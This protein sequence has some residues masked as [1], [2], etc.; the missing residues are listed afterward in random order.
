MILFFSKKTGQCIGS[1]FGRMHTDVH[2]QATILPGDHTEEEVERVVNEWVVTG[3]DAEGKPIIE[4]EW[5]DKTFWEEI[6]EGHKRIEHLHL[7]TV[8]GVKGISYDPPLDNQATKEVKSDH[9]NV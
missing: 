6:E 5:G 1:I 8:N 2:K 7:V 4:P 3:N 9:G